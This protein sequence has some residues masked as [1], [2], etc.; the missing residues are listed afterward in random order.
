MTNFLELP[1][2]IRQKIYRLVLVKN[3][4][5]GPIMDS[6]NTIVLKDPPKWLWYRNIGGINLLRTCRQ[7]EDE[8]SRVLYSSGRFFVNKGTTYFG[9][10]FL[11]MIGLNARFIRYLHF[12]VSDAWVAEVVHAHFLRKGLVY[13]PDDDMEDGCEVLTHLKPVFHVTELGLLLGCLRQKMP[14]LRK[15]SFQVQVMMMSSCIARDQHW[16]KTVGLPLPLGFEEVCMLWL[17]ANCIDTHEKL[18]FASWTESAKTVQFWGGVRDSGEQITITVNLVKE[19]DA[20]E[21]AA[22]ALKCWKRP[23]K[24]SSLRSGNTPSRK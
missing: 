19:R 10:N 11:P 9:Q 2:E 20:D 15:L 7:I 12:G 16:S 6:S 17:A 3:S 4:G 18:R 8:A 13:V 5:I 21:Q 24:V 22:L 1:S 14:G 23:V